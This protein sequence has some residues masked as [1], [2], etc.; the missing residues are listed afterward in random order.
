MS[1]K[2]KKVEPASST[3]AKIKQVNQL[4]RVIDDPAQVQLAVDGHLESEGRKILVTKG[5]NTMTASFQVY[6]HL[7]QQ[8]DDSGAPFTW[9][10]KLRGLCHVDPTWKQP[11]RVSGQQ[12]MDYVDKWFISCAIVENLNGKALQVLDG[13]PKLFAAILQQTRFFAPFADLFPSLD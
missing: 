12:F 10:Y 5:G 11:A 9:S 7:S 4:I 1:N 8:L 13:V 6:Y 2:I 3:E